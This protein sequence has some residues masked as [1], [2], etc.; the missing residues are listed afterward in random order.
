MSNP[1]GDESDTVFA[2]RER[3]K[4]KEF[5]IQTLQMRVSELKNQLDQSILDNQ[6]SKQEL[7][8]ARSEII[9]QKEEY[10]RIS[11]IINE[12][13]DALDVLQTSLETDAMAN[14]RSTNK[15]LQIQVEELQ[16]QLARGGGGQTDFS[17]DL[18]ATLTPLMMQVYDPNSSR[19]QDSFDKFV[20][21]V[22]EHGDIFQ[23][24]I[25]T[26]IK[27][28][29]SSSIDIVKAKINNEEFEAA[30]EILVENEILK[31]VDDQLMVVTSETSVSA[32][33]NWD[34]LEISEVFD[35]MKNIIEVESD[36]NVIRSIEKFRDTLQ[37]REVPAKIFFEIRKMS[38]G[39]SSNSMSRSEAL[40][41][42]EDWQRRVGSV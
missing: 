38:E 15:N 30:V 7:E 23:K 36:S 21:S 39:L 18:S 17:S 1:F 33:K 8:S 12:K 20:S 35:L 22:S 40:E 34:E 37:E 13:Q 41:Q 3:Y 42:I 24:I 11:S 2:W 31:T 29:G 10:S 4:Q 32:D 19:F 6:T 28:N 27:Y 5:E 25:G 16:S 26:L 14:L 9:K